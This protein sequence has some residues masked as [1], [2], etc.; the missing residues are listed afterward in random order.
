MK[1]RRTV[2]YIALGVLF[3]SAVVL[4]PGVYFLH[5]FQVKRNAHILLEEANKAEADGHPDKAFDYLGQY[6]GMQ[7]RDD[8]VAAR[9]ALML[10]KNAK[11]RGQKE[12]VLYLLDGILNRDPNRTDLRLHAARV[13]VE[14]P[15]FPSARHHLNFLVNAKGKNDIELLH[16]QARCAVAEKKYDEALADYQSAAALDQARVDISLECAELQRKCEEPKAADE[17]IAGMLKFNDDPENPDAATSDTGHRLAARLAAARYYDRYGVLDSAAGSVARAIDKLG[18]NEADAFLLASRVA[19]RRKDVKL[20]REYIDRGRKLHPENSQ[21]LLALASLEQMEGNKQAALEAIKVVEESLPSDPDELWKLGNLLIDLGELNKTDLVI[22]RLAARKI[23]WASD[24]LKGR[25]RFREQAWAEAR[26]LFERAKVEGATPYGLGEIN[27]MLARCY[28]RLGNPDEQLAAARRALESNPAAAD[29]QVLAAEA[30]R[31]LGRDEDAIKE[32]RQLAPRV[33][34]MQIT[35]ARLLLTRTLKQPPG[36]RQWDELDK[37]MGEFKDETPAVRQLR[38]EVLVGMGEPDEARKRMEA[39]RDRDPKEVGPWLFLIAL[40]E[41]KDQGKGVPKLLDD[42]QQ[43]TGPRVEWTLM[44]ANYALRQ[45]PEKAAPELKELEG[46]LKKF[47]GADRESLLNG[48]GAAYLIADDP[49]R[50]AELWRMLADSRPH[51]LA[52]RVRLMELAYRGGRADELARLTD[53]VRALDGPDG[54]VAN[55]GVAAGLLLK[56][57][58]GDTS[59]LTNAHRRLRAAAQARPSWAWVPLLDA[60]V[61]DLEN[62][63]DKALEKYQAAVTLGESRLFVVRKTLDLLTAQGRFKEAHDL[64]NRFARSGQ[65]PVALDRLNAQLTLL[66]PGSG[67]ESPEARKRSLEVALGVARKSIPVD[68]KNYRDYLWLGS[69]C[70]LAGERGDAEKAFRRARDLQADA[71]EAWAALILTLS[72]TDPKAAEAEIDAARA[73]LPAEARPLVLAACYEALGK[74]DEAEAEYL[75]AEKARPEHSAVLRNFATFY[76]ITG[77]SAKAEPLLAKLADSKGKASEA[78]R[79][80]ARRTLAVLLALRGTY[81][82]YQEARAMLKDHVE[83]TT[84]DRKA[85]ALILTTRSETRREAIKQF[86][87]LSAGRETPSPDLQFMLAQLYEADGQW[88][89]SRRQLQQLTDANEKNVFFQTYYARALLRHENV[90]EA[91]AVVERLQELK[92]S[93]EEMLQLQALVLNK[94]QKK[95]EAIKLVR[96]YARE[97]DARLN[98]AALLLDEFEQ[99]EDAEKMFRAYAAV[100][101]EKADVNAPLYLIQH[102]ARHEKVDEALEECDKAYARKCPPL[103]VARASVF[104]VSKSN[105]KDVQRLEDQRLRVEKRLRVLREENPKDLMYALLLAELQN[106]RGQTR[107]AMASYREVLAKDP[108]NALALNN[109]AF[110]VAVTGG[111]PEEALKLV[112]TAIDEGGPISEFLDTQAVVYL[113]LKRRD[114]ALSDLEQALINGPTPAM[115]FHQAQAYMLTNESTRAGEAFKKGVEAGLKSTDLHPLERPAFEAMEKE[116]K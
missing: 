59:V 25:L 32:Y 81:H 82:N 56:A 60:E 19:V 79:A 65:T 66:T 99:P 114:A 28:G 72:R 22:E 23:L 57:R 95:E 102:L 12:K 30:L 31:A 74:V 15:D 45:S 68:S 14:L 18:A 7:P 111:S 6:L 96:E 10:D 55:F 21:L 106:V 75:S 40:A 58:R 84:D 108:K 67:G 35:V 98:L 8:E 62:R 104:V 103:L 53:E 69:M 48:L 52:V 83:D 92:L 39:E 93:R 105:V 71:P 77:R 88:P 33:P 9:Y 97:K 4:G 73:K 100:T 78:S 3:G 54:G 86:E 41:I 26:A 17:T 64:L 20:A 46:D 5:A 80:W 42:A 16:L 37:A 110:L 109:L 76:I 2:N 38:A 107:E 44:R 89:M 36:S 91:R 61:F 13:A 34:E 112:Q 29:A 85:W 1:T 24:Y 51:E 27:T 70:M 50:A 43:A 101:G 63:P 115:Y 90:D 113:R 47:K 49:D 116:F 11:T 94:S 87:Q